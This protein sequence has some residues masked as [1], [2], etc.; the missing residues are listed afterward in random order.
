MG[1]T[2][3]LDQLKKFA[4]IATIGIL[5]AVLAFSISDLVLDQPEYSDFCDNSLYARPRP[6]PDQECE[7]PLTAPQDFE[8]ECRAEGGNVRY[9]LDEDGCAV[10]YVCDMC[11]AEYSSANERHQLFSFTM[12]SLIGLTGIFAGIYSKPK[13]EVISWLL[14]GFIIGGLV[15][16]F[17][18][19]ISFFNAMDPVMRPLV[20]IAEIV[21][22]AWLTIR[23]QRGH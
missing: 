9:E 14:S 4:V 19:T 11:S 21:L 18:A 5:F 20:I 22:V 1:R 15:S 12:V 3:T 8:Q 16:I 23:L 6:M 2:T 17:V 10:D 7:D 13:D